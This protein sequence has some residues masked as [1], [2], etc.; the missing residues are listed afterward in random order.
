MIVGNI[1]V[2][3]LVL[4]FGGSVAAGADTLNI[5]SGIIGIILIP[6]EI[7]FRKDD[8]GFRPEQNLLGYDAALCSILVLPVAFYLLVLV[9]CTGKTVSGTGTSGDRRTD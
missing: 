1:L 9:L 4:G 6:S 2:T 7:R 5:Q 8:I 3:V